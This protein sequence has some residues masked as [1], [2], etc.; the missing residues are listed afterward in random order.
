MINRITRD[1]HP[2]IFEYFDKGGW[3]YVEVLDQENVK[4]DTTCYDIRM[5]ID[6]AVTKDVSLY[7]S[8]FGLLNYSYLHGSE[9]KDYPQEL[10]RIELAEVTMVEWVL[11]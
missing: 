7:G 4:P 1:T 3:D 2:E 10:H 11:V 9:P 5:V 6:K 8:W